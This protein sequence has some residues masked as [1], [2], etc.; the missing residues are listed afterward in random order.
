MSWYIIGL[1]SQPFFGELSPW[2]VDYII[3]HTGWTGYLMLHVLFLGDAVGSLIVQV[4]Y[5]I[6]LQL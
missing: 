1:D 3:M 5:R 2:S 4:A 6:S